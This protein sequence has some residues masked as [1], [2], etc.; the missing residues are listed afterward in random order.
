MFKILVILTLIYAGLKI[1]N[2]RDEFRRREAAKAQEA[3]EAAQ[4]MEEEME[5]DEII[6]SAIDV[7]DVE[8][9]EEA[10]VNE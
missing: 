8:V 2:T 5:A 3:Q 4:I 6:N 9:V 7:D 1:Y 10:E